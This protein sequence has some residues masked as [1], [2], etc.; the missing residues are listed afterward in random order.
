MVQIQTETQDK[1][2]SRFSDLHPSSTLSRLCAKA[3]PGGRNNSQEGCGAVA[4]SKSS[5]LMSGKHGVRTHTPSLLKAETVW[6]NRL[7]QPPAA[8]R[9]SACFRVCAHFFFFL[10]LLFFLNALTDVVCAASLSFCPVA[11][12]PGTAANLFMN[13]EGKTP[14]AGPTCCKQPGGVP[15][16]QRR[17]SRCVCACVCERAR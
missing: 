8:D 4:E 7:H 13:E 17:L 14:P 2:S 9:K 1:V 16:I 12:G 6:T 11:V 10:L 5:G 3:P 15:G